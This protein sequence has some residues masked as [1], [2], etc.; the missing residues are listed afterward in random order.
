MSRSRRKTPISGVTTA[1]S[2]KLFKRVEHRR[3]RRA[4]RHVLDVT[5]DDVGIPGRK[6]FGDPWNSQKDG[7]LRIDV[8]K[9][10]GVK[11]MRK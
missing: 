8:A 1:R 5:V 4:V 11:M 10:W 9:L 6:L 7:K 2:D 3:E